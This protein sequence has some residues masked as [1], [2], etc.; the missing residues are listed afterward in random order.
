[1]S[2]QKGAVDYISKPFQ[3]DKLTEKIENI[4]SRVGN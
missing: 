4:L 1:M 3:Y 2:F